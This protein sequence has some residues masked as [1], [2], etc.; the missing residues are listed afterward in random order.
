M[1]EE[2]SVSPLPSWVAV[3]NDSDD[4]DDNDFIPLRTSQVNT[5]HT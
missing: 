2:G 3:V 4:D 5:E 1:A